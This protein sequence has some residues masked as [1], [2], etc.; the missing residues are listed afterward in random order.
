MPMREEL[1]E[2]ARAHPVAWA[3][4]AS[5]AGEVDE[6][7]RVNPGD[8]RRSRHLEHLADLLVQVAQRKIK[9][10]CVSMPPRHGKSE[11]I[12]KYYASWL[13]GA[14]P[15]SRVVV[16]SYGAELTKQWS[17]AARDLLSEYGEE[18]FGATAW[19]RAKAAEWWTLDPLGSRMGGNFYAVG[20]G[21]ALTGRG[22]DDLIIDDL[23]KD[24][25]EANSPTLREHAWQWLTSA[26]LTRLEPDAACVIVSTRWHHDD[27]IGRLEAAQERGE[28][29]GWTFLNLPAIATTADELGR[30]PGDALW[31]ERF[32]LEDLARI[33]SEVGAY[34]WEALY[35]GRPT[36]SEGGFFKRSWMHGYKLEGD[37]VVVEGRGSLPVDGLRRFA[38]V[39]LAAS[40]KASADY[41][42]AM[43]WG[44]APEWGILFLLDVFRER[45]EGPAL[46]PLLKG[47]RDRWALAVLFVERIGFQLTLIQAARAA[48]LPIR[49]V[50]PDGDKVSRALP[51]TARMEAAEILFPL[52]APF[53]PELER[54]LLEFP[55]GTHD[56][57]VDALAYAARV[58]EDLRRGGGGSQD[59][60]GGGGGGYTPRGGGGD[61]YKPRGGSDPYGRRGGGGGGGWK[62]GR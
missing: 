49:E 24:A 55:R 7:G 14:R 40:A 21:G 58:F 17:G 10:L 41:T 18:V 29:S 4:Y 15:R 16:A 37:R 13:M 8:W 56:D 9:R 35:Q 52:G 34:V 60:G 44:Y 50:R 1:R 38:T 5:G 42:V 25:A 27:H 33:R 26:A 47:V 59:G 39:D 12:S 36:P 57:Q 6:R 45:V 32:A 46:V 54:E 2:M 53:M 22:A 20:K 62:I 11:L 61:S 31:P 3:M 48:G 23:F 43:V 19:D 30:Q 28:I 51:A